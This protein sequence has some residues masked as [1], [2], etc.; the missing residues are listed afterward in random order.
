MKKT[1][2]FVMLCALLLVMCGCAKEETPLPDCQALAEKILASQAFSPEMTA[3][4][5]KKMI[6]ALD[7]AQGEYAQAYMMLDASRVT[8][9]A[10]VVVTAAD[11]KQTEAVEA[12]LAAYRDSVLEQYRTYQVAEVPKLEAAEVMKNG[13]QCV[14]VIAGDQQAA[15]S[16][17]DAAWG[18]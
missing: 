8:A 10:I 6:R 16:A 3:L 11:S 18:R 1:L 5:E 17:A 15:R 13:R 4:S 14:L 12:K 7:L 2:C 9:E